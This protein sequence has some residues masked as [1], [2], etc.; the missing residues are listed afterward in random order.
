VPGIGFLQPLALLVVC[1]DTI[2]CRP[3][4][5]L[6]VIRAA[7]VGMYDAGIH[8]PFGQSLS[9][10]F[11]LTGHGSPVALNVAPVSARSCALLALQS[12][13]ATLHMAHCALLNLLGIMAG[14]LDILMAELAF[15]GSL[16]AHVR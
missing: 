12:A 10:V 8:A 13:F 2:A 16:L 11:A 14:I 15:H 7:L 1:Q 4:A 5:L 6:L 3:V 9:V